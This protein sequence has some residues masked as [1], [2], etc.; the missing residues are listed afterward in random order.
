MYAANRVA[1]IGTVA[2]AADKRLESSPTPAWRVARQSLHQGQ[3]GIRNL[4]PA[5]ELTTIAEQESGWLTPAPRFSVE[6][7]CLVTQVERPIRSLRLE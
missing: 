4:L 7:R 3:S 5:V 2:G 1:Q 6:S